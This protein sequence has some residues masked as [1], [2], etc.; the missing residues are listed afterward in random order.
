MNKKLDI[1]LINPFSWTR[2]GNPAYLPYG[3]LYLASYLRVR[4]IQV[5]VFDANI[6][7]R[8][9]LNII[10]EKRPLAIGLSVLTGPVINEA[11]KISRDTRRRFSDIKIIWG[12]LHPTLFPQYVLKED[13]AD[14]IIQGEG[15]KSLFSLMS[16]LM[17]GKFD[18]SIPNLGY[19]EGDK[20]FINPIS[21]NL[22]DLNLSPMPAWDLVN[23]SKYIAN[24][25]FASR[26]LTMNT[27]R[28]CPFKCAFCFNQ[29]L[30]H[31]RWRALRAEKMYEQLIHLKDTYGINGIQFYEDSF[32]TDKNRVSGFCRLMNDN[33]TKVNWSHFS[34]IV[35]CNEEMLRIEKAGNC[36]YIEY[37]VES[38]S[39]RILKMVNKKQTVEMIERAFA[40]C[41]KVG[42]KSAALFMIGYPT[43]TMKELQETVDLV[44][45]LPAHILICTIYRPYPGT[46]LHDYCVKNKN[47][48]V[49]DSL[50]EQ[51]EFY[52]FSHMS[53][54]I[55]N[56]SEVPTNYLLK[57][58]K[59]FYAK[60]AIRE[61]LLCLRKLNFGLSIY[62]LKQQIHP[63]A[64][65]YT[66]KSLLIRIGFIFQSKKK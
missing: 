10:E 51:G 61:A 2:G 4:G 22:I 37:G 21:S 18:T 38:G 55:E 8:D 56:M 33:R 40:T 29:G 59:S 15:E 47:F 17:K 23:I 58:Q 45:R 65:F 28:G 42:I 36:K 9:P 35:Y 19:K 43:E 46:P 57:L 34:N 27:S 14:F 39:D 31:Q 50:E 5:D 26:V 16:S 49:P 53:D 54:D 41:K 3:I 52:R 12:G 6:D 32:D 30:P 25:F 48:H 7:L 20:I 44:E 62:Y 11:L 63:R 13:S 64:F 66:I 24:R 1:L 60:F